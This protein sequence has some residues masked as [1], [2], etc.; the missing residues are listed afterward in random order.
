M[1]VLIINIDKKIFEPNSA[2]LERLKEY[3]GFCEK[4]SVVVLTQKPFEPIIWGNLSVFA[5][6]SCCRVKYLFDALKLAKKIIKGEKHD[7]VLTQDPFDTGLMGWIIKKRYKIPWQCQVHGDFL[8]PYFARES[9]I[10]KI[11][12]LLLKF[13]LPKADGIRAVSE[14][15]RKS[16][17]SNLKLMAD[18]VVLPIFVDVDKFVSGLVKTDLKR[19]YP[20]FD[21]LILVASRLSQEKNISLSIG[22]MSDIVKRY[23]RVGLLIVGEGPER[24]RLTREIEKQKLSSNIVFEPWSFDLISYYKTTDLFLL[25]SNHEGWG[26]S[27]VEA[28]ACACPVIMTDVGCAGE[29]I[30]DGKSGIVI[31]VNDK[32]ALILAVEKLIQDRDIGRKMGEEARKA[33][34]SLPKREQYL[35]LYEKSLINT[36]S[37]NRL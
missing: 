22:A 34:L 33:A 6:A 9:L 20:Q 1:K 27:I 17:L 11:R 10:N 2:S 24:N 37:K 21:F 19:K 30:K 16:L 12:I 15:I 5:T 28:A 31:G 3:A 36:I 35:S 4:L 29:L 23:K 13:L 26:M 8:S 18:P 14:R 25:T 32:K 7:L